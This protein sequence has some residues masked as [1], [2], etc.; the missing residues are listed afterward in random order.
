MAGISFLGMGTLRYRIPRALCTGAWPHGGVYL[1]SRRHRASGGR[2]A[3]AQKE[4]LRR[5]AA[6]HVKYGLFRCPIDAVGRFVRTCA[7][8]VVCD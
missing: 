8:C 1:L 2:C 4:R 5:D 3:L 6:C 7:G